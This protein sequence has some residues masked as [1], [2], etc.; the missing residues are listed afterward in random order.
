MA[1]IQ[2]FVGL[3]LGQARDFTALAVLERSRPAE[4]PFR[5]LLQ[6]EDWSEFDLVAAQQTATKRERTY[7]VRHLERFPLGTSY[8]AICDRIV[9]LFA[10]PPVA[11]ATLVVDQTGVGRAVVD[12]I[13]RARPKATIRPVT[14]TSGLEIVPDGAGWHVPK[15]ELVTILQVLL[16]SRRLRVAAKLPMASVL[17]KE[18]ESFQVKITAA[19]HETFESWRERD[20]DDLVLSVALAAWVA[21]RGVQDL[22]V[23]C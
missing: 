8:P 4:D 22:W 1:D 19:A 15:K 21:E 11:R 5:E 10:K 16:Q 14:I 12:M 23:A 20:H 2:Y 18:L 6:R 17:I 3:D 7:A 9:E 13:G